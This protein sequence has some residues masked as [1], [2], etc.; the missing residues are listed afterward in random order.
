MHKK[1][2]I[3]IIDMNTQLSLFKD[4][5]TN[6]AKDIEHWNVSLSLIVVSSIAV[7]MT[8]TLTLSANE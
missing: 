5:T 8:K 7:Q 6:K 1:A 4:K 2:E 3:L